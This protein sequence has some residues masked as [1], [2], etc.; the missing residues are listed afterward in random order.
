MTTRRVPRLLKECLAGGT[1]A[2][3]DAL[4]LS[5]VEGDEFTALL[6]AAA[7]LRDHDGNRCRRNTVSIQLR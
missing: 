6:Q 4:L 3:G 7:G 2:P 5:S 1:L